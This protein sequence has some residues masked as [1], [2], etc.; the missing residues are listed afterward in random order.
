NFSAAEEAELAG[1][2]ALVAR[3]FSRG[4][5]GCDSRVGWDP[6]QVCVSNRWRGSK[7][8]FIY[9]T[10]AAWV[11]RKIAALGDRLQIR[12]RTCGDALEG[13]CHSGWTDWN[14]DASRCAR[15]ALGKR[16]HR[17]PRDV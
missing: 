6:S 15:T 4:N 2:R 3:G 11:Y 14:S 7:S 13:H 16:Q 12:S 17:G 1:C 8:Q 9:A 5:F 10:R